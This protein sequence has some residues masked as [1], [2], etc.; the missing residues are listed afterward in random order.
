MPPKIT[1]SGPKYV[2]TKEKISLLC[3]SNADSTDSAVIFQVYNQFYTKLSRNISG[4][5]IGLEASI[6]QSDVCQCFSDGRSFTLQYITELYSEVL[7]FRCSMNFKN[8]GTLSDCLFV[9]VVG[10]YI[11]SLF[12]YMERIFENSHQNKQANKPKANYSKTY[13]I[14]TIHFH[15]LVFRKSFHLGFLDIC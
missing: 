7:I 9:S 14:F 5:F 13:T 4:C 10:V 11:I 3:T 2:K 1:L 15:V 6:C 12:N 8:Y